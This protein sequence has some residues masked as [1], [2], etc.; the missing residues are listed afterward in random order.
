MII[1]T[2]TV[3]RCF[4][5]ERII[6][7]SDLLVRLERA[8]SENIKSIKPQINVGTIGHAGHGK[9]T[10]TAALTTV[11]SM[12][13]GGVAYGVDQINSVE[14]VIQFHSEFIH[15]SYVNYSTNLHQ[16][17]HVDCP[18]NADYVK[19]MISGEIRMDGA[20]LV[21]AAT[22]GIMPQTREHVRLSQETGV[23]YIVVFLNKCDVMDDEELLELV[24]L[25]IRELL[26]IYGYPGDDI[27]IIR[28]SALNAL[29]GNEMWTTKIL[30]LAEAMD[31]YIPN[32][33]RDVDKPF[34]MPVE[35]VFSIKGRGIVTT[36]RIER[37]II[38]VGDSV[39]LAGIQGIRSS[40][41][42][43]IEMFRKLIDDILPGDNV[44]LLLRGLKTEDVDQ[45]DLVVK[46]D[47][48]KLYTTFQSE[49]YVIAVNRSHPDTAFSNGYR[50]QFYFRNTGR[51]GI[52]TLLDGV[53]IVEPADNIN[54]LVELNAYTAME[55]TQH[56]VIRDGRNTVG[57][58]VVT[59][60]IG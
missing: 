38:K 9:T 48:I 7:K 46:P 42:T 22:D 20:I 5:G 25:E 55:E 34:L 23:S 57:F 45:G 52:I 6:L 10:L 33:I 14:N 27:P 37:G 12:R 8:S 32:P 19:G 30:E 18:T 24:E 58:G 36:G 41:C 16:F 1:A 44:G 3:C 50:A 11:L 17:S 15:A 26:L 60:L 53:D 51:T 39:Q 21:V 28:G 40:V 4:F 54:I 29:D 31:I 56:F 43:G 2:G 59:K 35:D 49:I 47:T 13:Y